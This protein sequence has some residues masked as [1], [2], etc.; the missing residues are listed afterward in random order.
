MHFNFGDLGGG[1][2]VIGWSDGGGG[3]Q[4]SREEWE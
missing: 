3:E 1:R 4:V 2:G